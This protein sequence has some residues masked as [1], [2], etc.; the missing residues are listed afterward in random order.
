MEQ[1]QKY[2]I[3]HLHVYKGD[4]IL[5]DEKGQIVNVNFS[6]KLPYEN[7]C[8]KNYFGDP[9]KGHGG[10][11][12]ESCRIDVIKITTKNGDLWEDQDKVEKITKEVQEAVNRKKVKPLTPEQQQ[13]ADLKEQVAQM[14]EM[15]KG[16][17]PKKEAIK[18]APKKEVVDEVDEVV[19]DDIEVL[20]AEYKKI[21][22]KNPHHRLS[23]KAIKQKIQEH[24]NN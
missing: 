9:I 18:E 19:E 17:A 16:Q 5:K 10:I 21:F 14:A 23:S 11:A 2:P 20:K 7:V 15:M 8:W 3:V 22:K 13:I 12:K 24:L 6:H 1:K 4:R